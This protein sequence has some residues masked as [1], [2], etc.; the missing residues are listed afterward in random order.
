V[1]YRVP[2]RGHW[3]SGKERRC[4]QWEISGLKKKKQKDQLLL[5]EVA[6]LAEDIVAVTF[7]GWIAYRMYILWR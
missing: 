4:E 2:G 6:C 3:S 1:D 5:W 7:G